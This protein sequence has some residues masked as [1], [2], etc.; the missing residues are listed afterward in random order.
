MELVLSEILKSAISWLGPISLMVLIAPRCLLSPFLG[1]QFPLQRRSSFFVIILASLLIALIQA[2]LNVPP[3]FYDL[4]GARPDA[5]QNAL[6][7]AWKKFALD[8]HPDRAGPGAKSRFILAREALD[9]LQND[10]QRFGYDRFGRQ[11][12][13]WKSQCT[14]VADYLDK[15]L[16]EIGVFYI[17]VFPILLIWS[18]WEKSGSA[19]VGN[20][21]GSRL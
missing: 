20:T 19:F 6:K 8:N 9:T 2:Y 21:R 12:T 3:S 7:A 14:T 1:C 11:T 17:I 16:S 18:I 5:D 15:G 10:V 4:L 13:E